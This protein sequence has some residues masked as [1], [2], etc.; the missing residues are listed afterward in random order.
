[1]AQSLSL[2]AIGTT[3][4]ATS[5]LEAINYQR[6]F[7]DFNSLEIELNSIANSLMHL[8]YLE[9]GFL[10][11]EQTNASS[12]VATY[13]LGERYKKAKIYFGADFNTKILKL[14]SN[15]ITDRYFEIDITNLETSLE[16]LNAEL[17]SIGNPFST[18]QLTNIKKKDGVLSADLNIV[19]QQ[20]RTLDTVIVKGYAKFPKSY[21]KRY[22]KIRSKQVFNLKSI[23]GKTE[24]LENL[25]FAAQ[26]KDP[27]VLFTK[28]STLLYIYVEKQKSN[29]FDGF[30]GFGT[31]SDS[32]KLEFDGY[33]NLNLINNLNYG[34]SFRLLY[35]S[36][37]SEQKTFDVK[38]K[39]PY[40]L[41]SPLG[42]QLGLNIFK[43]DSSFV[44]TTQFAKMDYQFDPKNSLAMGI[45]TQAST[46]L[47]DNAMLSI[48]DFKSVF[49]NL[50]YH[51][52]KP[53]HYDK[54]FPINFQFDIS[55]GVGQR[56]IENLKESQTKLELN[57]FKIVNLN[58]KN[59]LYGQISASVLYSDTYI[60]NELFRFGGINSIRGFEEQSLTANLYAVLNTEYRYRVSSNL[61]V[62]SI[63]DLA[64][65]EN[66]I[67]DTKAKL[68]GLGFG[69]GVLTQAG[70]FKLNYSN[71]SSENQSIKLSNS[72]IHISLTAT[73]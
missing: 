2:K 45:N 15:S 42:M 43:R 9:S 39:L 60:E 35:K 46:N 4:D 29:T 62:N 28:D 50:S 69:F 36:D 24:A 41:G 5:L 57:S 52:S 13:T 64:Y 73:F 19:E 37:E 26:I 27:E 3:E 56:T 31:N 20:Q 54:L 47:L 30:L 49:Y 25:Q 48:A 14:V 10:G 70:L 18:L 21:V 58:L 67:L 34:E 16:T 61:Y 66:Q 72:K 1:M 68:L 71:G 32:D 51:H 40:L 63:I 23:K 7:T 17:A 22:L 33:L 8:G 53:Q 38:A 11:L 65:Y 6:N 55:A 44:T 12:F 59:S